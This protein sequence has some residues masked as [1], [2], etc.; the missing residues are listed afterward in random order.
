[1]AILASHGGADTGSIMRSVGLA[2]KL[3]AALKSQ[4]RRIVETVPEGEVYV[5]GE[6]EP[7]RPLF[8]SL[9]ITACA[10]LRQNSET[11]GAIVFFDFLPQRDGLNE[12]D[13]ALVK[14]LS[15]YAGPSL[16][17]C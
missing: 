1:M 3:L 12:G 11:K 5:A 9:G 13:H 16:F 8:S 15:I 10:P 4:A 7:S 6:S 2:P 14:L 17:D